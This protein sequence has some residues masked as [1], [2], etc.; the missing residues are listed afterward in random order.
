LGYYTPIRN[1]PRNLNPY[2]VAKYVCDLFHYFLVVQ[3]ANSA[4]FGATSYIIYNHQS[5]S[6]LSCMPK[7]ILLFK[8][9]RPPD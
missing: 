2:D 3:A 6:C 8:P 9:L 7:A 5:L 1:S 4:F